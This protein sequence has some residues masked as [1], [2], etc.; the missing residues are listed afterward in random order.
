[1][2]LGGSRLLNTHVLLDVDMAEVLTPVEDADV[3]AGAGSKLVITLGPACQDVEV[4][5]QMLLAGV[6]CARV[7]LTWGS[8]DYHRR[9][10][11]N[12]STAMKATRRLCSVWLDTTGREV[13]VERGQTIVLTTDPTA[14]AS[15]SL[16]PVNWPGTT[17][18]VRK[19]QLLQVHEVTETE[20][21]C[22][23]ENSATLDG[24]LTVVAC[25]A[26]P[27]PLSRN[28]SFHHHMDT[29]ADFTMPV[30]TEH[31]LERRA[32]VQNFD[33][34]L[35]ASDGIVI[36]RGNMGLDFDAEASS[37]SLALLLAFMCMHVMAL[38]QKRMVSRCNVM[39]KPV[40]LTR[41]V[42]TMVNTPRPTRAEA[43]DV[44]NAVLDGVDGFVLGQETLRGEY[45]VETVETVLKLAHSAEKHFDF[46]THHE[47]LMGEAFEEEVAIQQADS[48]A[49][50][51]TLA[52][53]GAGR[54]NGH[55]QLLFQ[56]PPAAA[57]PPAT[58][59]I[60][61]A[62]ARP[63]GFSRLGSAAAGGAPPSVS[64][65]HGAGGYGSLRLHANGSTDD[66]SSV[67]EQ[68]ESAGGGGGGPS[69]RARPLR[70]A[71]SPGAHQYVSSF[72]TLPGVAS[73]SAV[74]LNQ[75]RGRGRGVAEKINAG[76]IIVMAQTGRTVSLVAKYRPPM[77]ILAVVVPTLR[78]NRLTWQL[79]GKYLARQTQ[80]GTAAGK[81]G[82]G[83]RGADD[84]LAEAI[85][86][87]CHKRLVR[88]SAFVVCIMSQRGQLVVK[89]VQVDSHGVGM[90]QLVGGAHP[91][92]T[93]D[94][95]V[96]GRALYGRQES[97]LAGGS[98]FGLPPAPPPRPVARRAPPPWSASGVSSVLS[99]GRR[100]SVRGS[101]GTPGPA[102]PMSP[103]LGGGGVLA[104]P[105]GAPGGPPGHDDHAQREYCFGLPGGETSAVPFQLEEPPPRPHTSPASEGL[106]S[107]KIPLNMRP[108]TADPASSSA[109]RGGSGRLRER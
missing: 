8:V 39:G 97:I 92:T 22:V 20:V 79:E 36:S 32:A 63:A 65:M 90:K 48:H 109:A 74:A 107:P 94:E 103:L 43:T 33:G 95:E 80:A 101:L 82:T 30:L 9:S 51:L 26:Q 83:G 14:E 5:S 50:L 7:D 16:L 31:D 106:V 85:S 1:M 73:R 55:H 19:G 23:A 76:L 18:V 56:P 84:L 42:D 105:F 17:Q 93:A 49:D 47:A 77:P 60:G 62:G 25:H 35:Q 54:P 104:S 91:L 6:T 58:P 34:I 46:R 40:V 61:G 98:P 12:L 99:P 102:P 29:A 68:S 13:T 75:A 24:L 38:L 81:R 69:P 88:A 37:S 2:P 21:K 108:L 57:S 10:L 53:A 67:G 15:S 27:A 3:K 72:G 64:S 28:I 66:L 78:S 41:V 71:A 86:T 44:A 96:A 87:A 52:T 11:E 89:V 4:L 59:S 100:P 70:R 45:P